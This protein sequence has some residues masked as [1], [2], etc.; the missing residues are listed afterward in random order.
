MGALL[1]G[2]PELGDGAPVAGEAEGFS[3]DSRLTSCKSVLVCSVDGFAVG[4]GAGGGVTGVEGCGEVG[5][6]AAAGFSAPACEDDPF[7]RLTAII[8]TAM[9][10]YARCS[11]SWSN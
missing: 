6:E 4:S 9:R 10:C 11:S 1:N 5:E 2:L 7:T 3:G 8:S